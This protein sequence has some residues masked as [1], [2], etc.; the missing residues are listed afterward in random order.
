[1]NKA[2]LSEYDKDC[3]S[4]SVAELV[5]K[6]PNVPIQQLE[7]DKE[8][9][10]EVCCELNQRRFLKWLAKNMRYIWRF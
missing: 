6:Y 9:I 3:L 10:E 1:M 5:A 7:S 2:Y 8:E 4:L